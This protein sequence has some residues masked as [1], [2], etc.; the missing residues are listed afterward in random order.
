M[1][2]LSS[3]APRSAKRRGTLPVA[4]LSFNGSIVHTGSDHCSLVLC[5][6]ANIWSKRRFDLLGNV[7]RCRYTIYALRY[8]TW[9]GLLIQPLVANTDNNGNSHNQT[10]FQHTTRVLI[11]PVVIWGPPRGGRRFLKQYKYPLLARVPIS[12]PPSFLTILSTSYFHNIS[13]S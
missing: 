6:T 12:S 11:L 2:N 7:T 3:Q 1:R 5:L 4:D 13:H 10:H 8:A 9:R